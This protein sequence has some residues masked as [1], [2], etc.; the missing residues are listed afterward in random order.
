MLFSLWDML[1]KTFKSAAP[2]MQEMKLVPM[3]NSKHDVQ[4]S[5]SIPVSDFRDRVRKGVNPYPKEFNDLHNEDFWQHGAFSRSSG[6]LDRNHSQN[7]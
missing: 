3:E 4:N 5:N 1:D 6:P 2:T 7:R